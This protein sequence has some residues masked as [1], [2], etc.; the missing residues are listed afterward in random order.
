M[1]VVVTMYSTDPI[2]WFF[3]NFAAWIQIGHLFYISSS[4]TKLFSLLVIRLVP[5]EEE[6][7]RTRC[8]HHIDCLFTLKV[9]HFRDLIS[10]YLKGLCYEHSYLQQGFFI[11][12][13]IKRS[14]ENCLF[15]VAF[16]LLK[17]FHLVNLK[18]CYF[19]YPR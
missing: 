13:G 4:L 11:Q 10:Y 19:V 14:I 9:I 8:W 15:E 1:H 5:L 12:N 6:N 18:L 17:D 16:R 7:L 2:V 3:N